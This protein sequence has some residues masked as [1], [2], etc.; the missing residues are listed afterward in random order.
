P[1]AL[2]DALPISREAR[3]GPACVKG[4]IRRRRS[5]CKTQ[6]DGGETMRAMRIVLLAGVAAVLWMGSA[7]ADQSS[8]LHN[9]AAVLN[10]LRNTPDKG[11]PE[12]L[13]NKAEC[14][15]VI[16]S[17]KKAAFILGGVV[18]PRRL[19]GGRGAHP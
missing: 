12:D 3:R 8:R 13:W 14:V 7:Y 15:S 1:L 18:Q 2:H 16:P 10:E 4:A 17:V 6:L 11:I 9:A 5:F 19:V